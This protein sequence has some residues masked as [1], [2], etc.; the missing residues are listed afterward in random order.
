MDTARTWRTSVRADHA[1]GPRGGRRR[2]GSLMAL[3]D[4]PLPD[5]PFEWTGVPEDIRP[6]VAEVLSQCD[7]VT[8]ELLDV[9]HRTAMRRFLSRVAVGDRARCSGA[10]PRRPAELSPWRG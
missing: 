10:R 4:T 9:E 7:R 5:Q 6:V 2:A 8:D 1:R 3:D